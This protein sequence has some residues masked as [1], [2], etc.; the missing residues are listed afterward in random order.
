MTNKSTKVKFLMKLL[1]LT[2]KK[3]IDDVFLHRRWSRGGGMQGGGGGGLLSIKTRIWSGTQAIY[4]LVPKLSQAPYK[5]GLVK[6]S[7]S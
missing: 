5:N 6:H 7:V 3:A 4:V 1:S 2:Y